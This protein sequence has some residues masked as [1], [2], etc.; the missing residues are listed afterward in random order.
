MRICDPH[1]VTCA[2]GYTRQLTEAP[3]IIREGDIAGF[4]DTG[5]SDGEILEVNQVCAYF[6]YSTRVISGLG[7]S[8]SDDIVGYY[9]PASSAHD[10]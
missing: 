3:W 5:A 2:L 6:I 1:H 10:S 9:A 8:L 7:V 4:G